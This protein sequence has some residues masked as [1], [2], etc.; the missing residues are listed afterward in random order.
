MAKARSSTTNPGQYEQPGHIPYLDGW[1]GMAILNVI[2]AH[3]F[4]KHIPLPFMEG[5]FNSGRF[6]VEMF[7]C[8]SGVLMGRILFLKEE[9]LGR[10]YFRRCTRIIPAF[11]VFTAAYWAYYLLLKGNPIPST[12][13]FVASFA[14][15]ANYSC[16][17]DIS[18]LPLDLRHLWS[19]SIEE[20]CYLLLALVAYWTRKTKRD[21]VPVI[22]AFAVASILC[23]GIH[24]SFASGDYNSTYWR[25]ECRLC[26][27]FISAALAVLADRKQGAVLPGN[28]WVY[29]LAAI[30][31]NLSIVPDALK[32]TLGSAMLAAFVSHLG[33]IGETWK[34]VLSSR[35]LVFIGAISYSW[36]LWQQPLFGKG[37]NV[38]SFPNLACLS[39]SVLLAF[40]SFRFLENPVRTGLNRWFDDRKAKGGTVIS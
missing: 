3:F 18:S 40:L 24:E 6:G 11:W 25:T 36:Y 14:F 34:R 22:L 29:L 21:A 35:F 16:A 33:F 32:Y 38:F 2:F 4:T 7:F 39:V 17:F 31:L 10:F 23:V 15:L 27:V 12:T 5:H 26:A 9:N 19:I 8:L 37:T 1:R 13:G 28:P 20:H 30:F